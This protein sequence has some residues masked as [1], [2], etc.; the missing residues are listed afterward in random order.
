M[1]GEYGGNAYDLK[2][3]VDGGAARD[4]GFQVLWQL[5]LV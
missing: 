3:G 1:N 5:S 4:K 2:T